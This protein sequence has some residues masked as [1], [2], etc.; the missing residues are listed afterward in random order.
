[1]RILKTRAAHNDTDHVSFAV[2]I[3]NN[4]MSSPQILHTG[5]VNDGDHLINLSFGP[6]PIDP[7][8]SVTCNYEI[9]NSGHQNQS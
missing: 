2:K 8:T 3:G 5:N 1:M 7:A 9:L 6:F 4:E